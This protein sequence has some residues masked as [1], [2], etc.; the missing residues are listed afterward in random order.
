MQRAS[1]DV[2]QAE[3]HSFEDA[4]LANDS[5]P[6]P[7]GEDKPEDWGRLDNGQLVLLDYGYACDTED[8]VLRMREYY[9][10]QSGA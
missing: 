3:I 9:E 4:W 10:S 6:L 2:T 5:R 7:T 1:Q 8:E